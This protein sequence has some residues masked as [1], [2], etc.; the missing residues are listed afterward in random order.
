RIQASSRG[1]GEVGSE[2]VDG[3][4]NVARRFCHVFG[5]SPGLWVEVAGVFGPERT[6][7]GV[8]MDGHRQRALR[9]T[10]RAIPEATL[11]EREER[12]TAGRAEQSV[13]L[14]MASRLVR[15][16]TSTQRVER[17]FV[18]HARVESVA[19]ASAKRL[20]AVRADIFAEAHGELS[21]S[22]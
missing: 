20:L 4:Q 8:H 21:R 10:A 19:A 14:D 22:L 16:A 13:L 5:V 9:H 1:I 6:L 7:A 18:L 15:D 11:R 2:P 17:I 3:L 12:P